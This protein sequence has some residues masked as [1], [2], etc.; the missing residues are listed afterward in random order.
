VGRERSRFDEPRTFPLSVRKIAIENEL[1]G[2]QAELE[3][4]YRNQEERIALGQRAAEWAR[5]TFS[6]DQYAAA[7][8]E[9]ASSAARA[10]PVIAASRLFAGTLAEWGAVSEGLFLS[11]Q[12]LGPLG[13]FAPQLNG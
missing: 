8:V 6:A 10:A 4:L 13:I 12:T 5:V 7:I 2:L 11:E 9:L 1:E 3:F